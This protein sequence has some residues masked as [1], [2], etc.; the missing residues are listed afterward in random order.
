MQPHNRYMN[1]IAIAIAAACLSLA[2]ACGE[3]G[4]EF[5]HG[6]IITPSAPCGPEV[7]LEPAVEFMPFKGVDDEA[8]DT[9]EWNQAVDK[10]AAR[11]RPQYER[12]RQIL[13]RYEEVIKKKSVIEEGGY[14]HGWAV[15]FQDT[16]EGL[17]SDKIIIKIWARKYV[18][19]SIYPPEDRIPECMDGI[20]VHYSIFLLQIVHG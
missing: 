19:Q 17:I 20:P 8:I 11:M 7:P 15:G 6:D 13:D 9:Q 3:D 18:D 4:P 16:E 10:R 2:T 5:A 12:A 14:I 1:I